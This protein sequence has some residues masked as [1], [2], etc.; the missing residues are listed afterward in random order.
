M[1]QSLNIHSLLK[2]GRSLE[3]RPQLQEMIVG[4]AAILQNA[5]CMTFS[6]KKK[7]QKCSVQNLTTLCRLCFSFS[8]YIK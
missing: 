2:T 1:G 4:A 3:K 6:V 7:K 8:S 5:S